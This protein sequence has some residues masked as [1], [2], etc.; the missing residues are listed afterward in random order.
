LVVYD[1]SFVGDPL[2]VYLKTATDNPLMAEVKTATGDP[3][4][5]E[6]HEKTGE[7]L[8]VYV[9]D[10]VGDP[11]V[12]KLETA[13]DNPEV[14][15]VK[16]E[17]GKPLFKLWTPLSINPMSN[18]V[19]PNDPFELI[20]ETKLLAAGQ[21][22]TI[23]LL[24]QTWLPD[25]SYESADMALRLSQKAWAPFVG[26]DF[27]MI[28]SGHDTK[29]H[30]NSG[31]LIAGVAWQRPGD[32]SDFLF[33][34]LLELVK[35]KYML[36]ADYGSLYGSEVKANG[37]ITAMDVGLMIRHRWSGGLRLE[38]S[39]RY[40]LVRNSFKS[41]CFNNSLGDFMDYEMKAPFWS[42]HAGLG[43]E[44][45]I[46]ERSNLDFIA[47]LYYT[48]LGS[49]S[50]VLNSGEKVNFGSVTSKRVRGGLRYSYLH[51][52]RVTFYAGGYWEQ[53]FDGKA[54]GEH[55]SFKFGADELRGGTGIGEMGV[56][57]RSTPDHPWDVEAG[58][59][60]YGGRSRGFSLGVRVGYEF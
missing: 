56:S 30:T 32:S 46:S 20:P 51:N 5:V 7:P 13:V 39:G 22:A 52:E 11:L 43:Y 25:H 17:K 23:G 58:L 35:G 12:V 49:D 48:R 50:V 9:K 36:E 8:V 14:V 16:D 27:A 21:A 15:Y 2:V 41:D 37:L 31:R 54:S 57:F 4:M 33:G 29:L 53:E 6:I 18:I 42:V 19:N 1:Y 34:V 40:G 47:R 24:N 45:K 55:L 10:A 59:Q 38:A 26:L 3:L 60:F 44:Y 28:E